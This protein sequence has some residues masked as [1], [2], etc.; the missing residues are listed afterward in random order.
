RGRRPTLLPPPPP[1]PRRR[2]AGTSAARSAAARR[3]RGTAASPFARKRRRARRASASAAER[4]RRP[5]RWP[6]LCPCRRPEGRMRFW[7]CLGA[8]IGLGLGCSGGSGGSGASTG[9]PLF[10]PVTSGGVGGPS[11]GTTTNPRATLAPP[12]GLRAVAATG[13]VTLTWTASPG[14]TGYAVYWATA[15]RVTPRSGSR[16]VATASPFVHAGLTAGTTYFYV[17]TATAGT[18]ESA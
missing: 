10:A 6:G 11:S 12:S 9:G 4:R 1:R 2:A 13:Q 7:F 16:L 14:A 17:V 18:T 15:P 3:M 8:V 5:A